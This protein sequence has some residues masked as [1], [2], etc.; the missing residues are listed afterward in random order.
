MTYRTVSELTTDA[1][2]LYSEQKYQEA[3]EL[4]EAHW[5]KFGESRTLLTHWLMC[6]HSLAGQEAKAIAYFRNLIE[7]ELWFPPSFL[8]D[9]DFEPLR[10]FSEFQELQA[11][12]LERYQTAQTHTEVHLSLYPTQSDVALP[13]LIACH[14][15]MSNL[16]RTTPLWQSAVEQGWLVALPQSSRISAP[17]LYV[18]ETMEQ[19]TAELIA[20]FEKISA[21][22]IQPERLVIGG[23]SRGG[24]LAF[25]TAV[26]QTLP[27]RGVILVAAGLPDVES[28]DLSTL[29][30]YVRFY[31][32]VGE[33]EKPL[34]SQVQRLAER[35]VENGNKVYVDQR[36]DIAHE[37]PADFPETLL[38]ALAFIEAG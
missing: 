4:L 15:N 17:G 31:I 28:I 24:A 20:H 34:V 36:P 10:K 35:L 16:E 29:P 13:V 27:V 26:N 2:N 9:A 11:V 23:F 19:G 21:R 37:Y 1:Y 32:I 8:E 12:S 5:Q 38:R 6:T 7:N 18:W 33:L 30:A 22:K 25:H 14:G 3:A